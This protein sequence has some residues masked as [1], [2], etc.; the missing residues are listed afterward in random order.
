MR[1]I[2][3]LEELGLASKEAQVYMALLELG[4]S[5]VQAI[6]R[7]A[8]MVRPTT[9]V[10]L[11][12]LAKKGLVSKV[13][14]PDAKKI[15]FAAEGPERLTRFLDLQKHL[16]EDRRSRLERVLPELRS[17]HLSGEERP[18]VRLF[19]GKE[20][21]RILQQEFINAS[22]EP[23][24]AVAAEDEMFALFPAEE[25][26][27][28][29]RS[30]R[31]RAGIPTRYIYTSAREP[32][33]IRAQEGNFLREDRFIPASVLPINAS[34][35]VH[36]PVLSIV[37]FRNKIIGV[38]IEHQ[39]VAASFRTLFEVLWRFADQLRQEAKATPQV[40]QERV[41]P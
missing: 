6:A 19:E 39:D 20:G 9:Y 22:T 32:R 18:R 5:S 37:T 14:G 8:R 12:H 28:A 40:E 3:E 21:L 27:Q 16:L 31:L 25:Y 34:F 38:L 4:T 1:L 15:L 35:A 33:D 7:R 36:G 30:I 24:C 11:E 2:R 17:L 26:H 13:T 29:I 10:I 41:R 23:V